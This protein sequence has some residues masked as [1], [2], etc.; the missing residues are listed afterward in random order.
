M[1]SYNDYSTH[2][3]PRYGRNHYVPP[4]TTTK[5][6][7]TYNL[8]STGGGASSSYRSH[9]DYTP[10]CGA[11]SYS[12]ASGLSGSSQSS[13]MS[14]FSNYRSS[15]A[16]PRYGTGSSRKEDYSPARPK[17][18]GSLDEAHGSITRRS[19]YTPSRAPSQDGSVSDSKYSNIYAGVLR[20]ERRS[21]VSDSSRE[22]SV[23]TT[24][25]V[26]NSMAPADK[27]NSSLLRVDSKDFDYFY[28]KYVKS[29]TPSD[30]EVEKSP[31]KE[32]SPSR[33]QS[34]EVASDPEDESTTLVKKDENGN[35][36]QSSDESIVMGLEDEQS[37]HM[38]AEVDRLI[39]TEYAQLNVISSNAPFLP[40]HFVDLAALKLKMCMQVQEIN[41]KSVHRHYD[42]N[43]AG[44]NELCKQAKFCRNFPEYANTNEFLED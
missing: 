44:T 40:P 19:V 36:I 24:G 21:V 28:D 5:F 8:G 6:T 29:E 37:M 27:N 38:V 17:L 13:S 25:G 33:E 12:Y 22:S 20:S 14:Q 43:S 34:V 1:R 26:R 23:S 2:S 9:S 16:Y 39:E 10:S 11:K 31:E 3:L 35:V 4:T 32:M 15:S 18:Y 30:K 41:Y 7:S 42:L